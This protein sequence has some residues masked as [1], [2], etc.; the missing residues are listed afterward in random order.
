M[1]PN[2]RRHEPLLQI[3]GL[4]QLQ[5][6]PGELVQLADLPVTPGI[7]RRQP[8]VGIGHTPGGKQPCHLLK[9]RR[10]RV[11]AHQSQPR[12]RLRGPLAKGLHPTARWTRYSSS[13]S[14][15]TA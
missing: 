4:L 6:L 10:V 9:Q 14:I 13:T 12:H 15:T 11:G 1:R 3:M 8:G 2:K 5:E 7:H